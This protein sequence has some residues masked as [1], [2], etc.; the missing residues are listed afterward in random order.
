MSR[1]VAGVGMYV[2]LARDALGG[3]PNLVC[4]V[5]MLSLRAHLD[6]GRPLGTKLHL[7]L[8]NTTAENKNNTVLGMVALLVAWGVFR[9]ASIFFMTVGH[10]YNELDAAF[11]PLID[12]MLSNVLP[13]ISSLLEFIP[14]ALSSK[15]VRVVRNLD[16]LWDFTAYMKQHMHE[17]IG[18]FTVTQ[19]SSGMHE[20]YFSRNASGEVRMTARQA[21]QAANWFPQGEGDPIFRTVPDPASAPPIARICSDIAWERSSV[22]VN[23]RRWLPFL[24]LP[25]HELNQAINEWESVFES[26]PEDGDIA[27]L[28]DDQRMC[29]VPFEPHAE[30]LQNA[31]R[32]HVAGY[33]CHTMT[34]VHRISI[35]CSMMNDAVFCVCAR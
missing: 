12:A 15:R 1:D 4:T 6:V 8:D 3:G 21:S 31:L 33:I 5:L 29:W 34:H 2:F 13:T 30:V 9:E 24:G 17:G 19:Q 23:V 28:R 22:A 11:A 20:F 35:T 14:I 26:L 32:G 10:T 7:Q 25:P 27:R 16:H 18:G